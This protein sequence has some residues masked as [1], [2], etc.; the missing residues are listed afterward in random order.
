MIAVFFWSTVATAFKITLE[1]MN[2]AQMLFY[3]SLISTGI[4]TV[5]AG[6]V[7]K[8][9]LRSN[10]LTKNLKRNAILGLANP[11]LY[12][13]ILFKAYDLL[14]AQEALAVNFTWP[15]VLSLFSVL[16]LKQKMNLGTV[17]GLIAAFFGVLTIATHG[18]ILG[19]RFHNIFGG[20]LALMSTIIW[21]GFWILN[22]KDNREN[23]LKLS[24]GFLFGTIY[25]GIFIL[26]FDSFIIENPQYLLG[27]IYIGLFE[28][29]LTFFFWLKGL[30]LS[31]NKAKT[32]TL[33]YLAPFL[34]FI[35]IAV[36]LKEP[37]LVSSIVG[38]CLIIGGIAI[39]HLIKS[40]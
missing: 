16:F 19:L 6:F 24:G 12:Y 18:D 33:A 40:D 34:S 15:V 11:F 22:L 29:G 32:S 2:F 3:S 4:L 30:D 9:G 27:P 23:S 21:A 17:I 39:Q 28:M 38:L 7:S 37:I 36:I 31:S 10:F 35:F 26:L 8:D 14:P 5:I 20:L 13:L 25:T 1:G